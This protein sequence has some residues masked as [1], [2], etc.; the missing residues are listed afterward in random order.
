MSSSQ[1][2]T[3]NRFWVEQCIYIY[4]LISMHSDMH[5][6]SEILVQTSK[7]TFGTFQQSL[8]SWTLLKHVLQLFLQLISVHFYI[9]LSLVIVLGIS[10][11][12]YFTCVRT[13]QQNLLQIHEVKFWGNSKRS[14]PKNTKK[15]YK[16]SKLMSSCNVP[17]RNRFRMSY[18]Y[19]P[20]IN[21]VKHLRVVSFS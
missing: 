21:S 11:Q 6:S 16:E 7:Q 13:M 2:D 3:K 8:S 18:Y 17:E 14:T 12:E 9:N 5:S 19:M 4:I 1:N 15:T 20:E 10:L